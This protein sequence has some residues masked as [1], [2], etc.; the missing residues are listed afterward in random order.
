M[1]DKAPYFSL[2]AEE[3]HLQREQDRLALE[4]DRVSKAQLRRENG[5][6]AVEAQIDLSNSDF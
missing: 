1:S 4:S 6:F 3:K 2:R 5:Y